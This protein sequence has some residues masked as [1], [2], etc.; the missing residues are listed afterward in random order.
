MIGSNQSLGQIPETLLVA[1]QECDRIAAIGFGTGASSRDGITEARLAHNHMQQLWHDRAQFVRLTA[2][3]VQQEKVTALVAAPHLDEQS[4]NTT[5]E[6]QAALAT[7]QQLGLRRFHGVTCP[8]HLPRCANEASAIFAGTGIMVTFTASEVPYT[9]VQ[10]GE[11]AVFEPP[12]RP[13]DPVRAAAIPLHTSLARFF[14]IRDAATKVRVA[15]ELVE[16]I[17]RI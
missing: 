7:M 16:V 9:G 17:E 1:I 4:H 6:L 11:V 13:D 5:E 12:H 3:A 14:R 2:T 15:Q 10:M 8:T